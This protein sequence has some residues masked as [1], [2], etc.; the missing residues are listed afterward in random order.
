M[1]VGHFRADDRQNVE[2]G[3]LHRRPDRKKRWWRWLAGR[4]RSRRVVFFLRWAMAA[5]RL[6]AVVVFP[7]RPSGWQRSGWRSYHCP[8]LP[9]RQGPRLP[10][11][12]GCEPCN[13]PSRAPHIVLR[14]QPKPFGCQKSNWLR[15]STQAKNVQRINNLSATMGYAGYLRGNVLKLPNYRGLHLVAAE[16]LVGEAFEP[17]AQ[18]FAG[19]LLGSGAGNLRALQHRL[20]HEDG[21]IDRRASARASLGRESMDMRSPSRSTQIS[22]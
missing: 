12:I 19:G 5:A 2:H 18:L 21:A 6:M 7:L 1:A 15:S 22:A 3:S 13:V 11:H 8:A 10:G 16:V 4:D 9:Q 20:F 14:L 17:L